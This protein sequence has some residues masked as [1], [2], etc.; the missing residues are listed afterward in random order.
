M[1]GGVITNAKGDRHLVYIPF[2]YSFLLMPNETIVPMIQQ[3]ASIL[4]L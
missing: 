2:R 1:S 4:F 3:F